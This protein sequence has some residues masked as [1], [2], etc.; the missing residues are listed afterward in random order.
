M[1]KLLFLL[2]S[3]VNTLINA[4]DIKINNT[5]DYP[6]KLNIIANQDVCPEPNHGPGILAAHTE[7][8]WPTHNICIQYVELHYP[9]VEY[10]KELQKYVVRGY[11]GNISATI[12]AHASWKN[13]EIY[14]DIDANGIPHFH[15]R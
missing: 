7:D 2:L 9:I 13:F 4:Y 15:W 11:E 12:T 5:T 6:V 1:K 3:I 8:R 14:A 10:S